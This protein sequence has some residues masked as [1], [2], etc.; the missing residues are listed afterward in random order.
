ME[1]EKRIAELLKYKD[2]YA[3]V[4]TRLET[5]LTALKDYNKDAINKTFFEKYFSMK[6]DSSYDYIP[7]GSKIGDIRKDWKG[8]IYTEFH[9]SDK[10]WDWEKY[11]KR[12]YLAES[13][14]LEASSNKRLDIIKETEQKIDSVKN[15]IANNDKELANVQSVDEKQLVADLIAVYKKHNAPEIWDKVLSSYEVKYPKSNE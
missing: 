3:K 7:E 13:E 5:L 15:W 4:L 8:N 1:K 2:Q 10:R 6:Y 14:Y 9:F 11:Y 12:I